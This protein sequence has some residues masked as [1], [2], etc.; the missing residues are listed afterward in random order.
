MTSGTC[1]DLVW[2]QG[3]LVRIRVSELVCPGLEIPENAQVDGDCS[4][5]PSVG[6]S[7]RLSCLPGSVQSSG[8]ITRTCL[9]D[10]TWSGTPLVCTG[11]SKCLHQEYCC[12]RHLSFGEQKLLLMFTSTLLRIH[13]RVVIPCRVC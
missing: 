7:C 4:P 6:D 3:Y 11:N 1:I 13:Y 8:S 2:L 10:I 5:V 9:Y 12:L